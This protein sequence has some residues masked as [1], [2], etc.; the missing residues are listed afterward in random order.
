MWEVEVALGLLL[1]GMALV[2]CKA[3]GLGFSEQNWRIK[4]TCTDVKVMVSLWE[5]RS[6][7][8]MLYG[9]PNKGTILTIWAMLSFM[10]HAKEDLLGEFQKSYSFGE[11]I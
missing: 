10:Y 7:G 6:F 11:C 8:V 4:V 5:T 2:G 9:K 1:W 3:L